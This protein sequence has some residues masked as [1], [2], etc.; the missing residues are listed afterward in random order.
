MHRIWADG[1]KSL[2]L[3]AEPGGEVYR[4][5]ES[6]RQFSFADFYLP[7]GGSLDG[8][9]RWVRLAG[10]I[11]WSEFESEYAEQFAASGQGAPAIRF[12]TALA[13]ILIKEKLRITDE[14]T[15]QQIRENPYLQ[16]F[17]GLEGFRREAPFEASMMVHFRSRISC[18]MLWRINERIHEGQVKK[19]HSGSDT[20]GRKKEDAAIP[21]RG[22]L[23]LDATCAPADIGYPTDIGILNEGR[24]KSESIIDRLHEKLKGVQKKVR[25]YR[26]VAR[27]EYL[28]VVKSRKPSRR[29][30]RRGIGKQLR[31]LRRNL[32][33]IKELAQKVGLTELPRKVYRDL[34]V[35]SEVYRQQEQLYRQKHPHLSGRI[36]SISQ[37]HVRPIVRGKAGRPT[38]FGAK[39]SVSVVDGFTFLYRMS[40]DPYNESEDLIGQIGRYY[41]RFGYYPESVHADK[42]YRNRKN[43]D[44]C[45][46]HGIRLSGPR[47]GRPT[48]DIGIR[49]AHEQLS[50]QDEL[51]RIPV[52]GKFGNGKRRYGLDR[53]MAKLPVTSFS[54]IAAIVL[55]MNL[56]KILRDLFLSSIPIVI[57]SLLRSSDRF[58]MTGRSFVG[59]A[60]TAA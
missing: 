16:Y 58:V 55:V 20:C 38:E 47:L 29:L 43:I 19:N 3:N 57:F 60:Q 21:N 39:I 17:I 49:K 32:K 54:T 14:E 48:Q 28:K 35:I 33:H 7:F 44:Y 13:A 52:E 2:H 53:I 1:R 10:L 50:R 18:E 42:I 11:P 24:E 8:E 4:Q 30:I 36:D 45:K 12:R 34:L 27:K 46:S 9:N 26:R 56:E 22:K 15:V 40:W 5:S 41:R 59:V 6:E 25:T 51:D 23:L 31:Y 37:P